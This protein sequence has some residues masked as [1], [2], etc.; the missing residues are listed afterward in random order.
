MGYL[1]VGQL[2]DP[3]FGDYRI[4]TNFK[5]A[6]LSYSTA[7]DTLTKEMPMRLRFIISNTFGDTTAEN[8]YQLLEINELWR[9]TELKQSDSLSTNPVVM[10][11]NIIVPATIDTFYVALDTTFARKYAEYYYTYTDLDSDTLQ[12]RSEYYS[13][14]MFGFQLKPIN[15]GSINMFVSTNVN[16]QIEDVENDTTYSVS[17]LAYA[18]TISVSNELNYNIADHISLNSYN[19]RLLKFDVTVVNRDSLILNGSA[20]PTKSLS[21]VEIIFYE[22]TLLIGSQRPETFRNIGASTLLVFEASLDNIA[23]QLLLNSPSFTASKINGRYGINVT[24]FING[25]IAGEIENDSREF[26]V[27]VRGNDGF[28][29]NTLLFGEGAGQFSPKVIATYSRTDVK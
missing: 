4:S 29:A 21:K 19:Q 16:L 24:S 26:Y 28:F 7:I 11:D 1:T 25:F 14:N 3:A 27:T 17:M 5:P 18:N 20:L 2:V 13:M 15:V 22:D 6:L 8:Q 12:L 23:D 10:A 9:A